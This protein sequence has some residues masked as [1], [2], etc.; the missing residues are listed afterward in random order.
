MTVMIG[1]I[2]YFGTRLI[3]TLIKLTDSVNALNVSFSELKAEVNGKVDG[4]RIDSQEP[5]GR[6]IFFNEQQATI[7]KDVEQRLRNL[8][9]G[10]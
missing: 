2:G 1:A 10:K 7:N 9:N 6:L 4:V 8:E 3:D 5:I